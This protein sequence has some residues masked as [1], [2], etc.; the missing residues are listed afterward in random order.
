MEDERWEL[1]VGSC[2]CLKN[3]D[4]FMCKMETEARALG[5]L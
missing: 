3:V 5:G 1:I 4:R 2:Q